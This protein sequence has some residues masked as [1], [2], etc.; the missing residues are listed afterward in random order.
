MPALGSHSLSFDSPLFK[1]QT[2]QWRA[3]SSGAP[4]S[5]TTAHS[6]IKRSL[7]QT[8]PHIIGALR[9]LAASYSPEALNQRGFSLY[10]DFRPEV[11]EWGERGRLECERVL[12]LRKA[13]GTS[14]KGGQGKDIKP[15]VPQIKVEDRDNT[16]SQDDAK[17]NV[18][19]YD[20]ALNDDPLSAED[21][22]ALAEMP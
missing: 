7:R 1:T 9:L 13:P 12:A 4:V 22:A 20:A 11:K 21:L 5:P 3:L 15:V 6:Y 2:D 16:M 10:A 18:D 14:D 17:Q 8:T 19:E